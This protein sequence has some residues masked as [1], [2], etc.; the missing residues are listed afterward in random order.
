MQIL[1]IQS[2]YK[3]M[4]IRGG[5]MLKERISILE[6]AGVISAEV[7]EFVN[8]VIDEVKQWNVAVLVFD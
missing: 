8:Q 4:Y 6:N 3:K 1:F 7:A 5:V 2:I